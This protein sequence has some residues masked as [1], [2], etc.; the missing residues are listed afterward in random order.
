ME[1][2]NIFANRVSD[3]GLIV[4]ID[5][6]HIQLKSKK[7]KKK[8]KPDNLIKIWAEELNTVQRRHTNGQHVHEKV[9]DITNHQGNANQNYISLYTCQSGCHQKV[10]FH[11][12]YI[13]T[14]GKSYEQVK[15][16]KS[17]EMGDLTEFSM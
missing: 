5:K 13:I 10:A 17:L 9:L 15:E 14:W 4:E 2:D 3:K 12:I 6:E 16:V 7:Y 1:W 8:K 11:K